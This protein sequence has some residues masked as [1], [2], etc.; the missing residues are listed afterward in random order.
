MAQPLTA[1]KMVSALRAEGVKI[2]E[3]SGWRTHN[4][5]HKGPWGGVNGIIIHHTA[6]HN[7]LHIVA[8]GRTGL[9][10][11]LA[12]AYL[13]KSGTVTLVGNGRANH[14]GRVAGNVHQAVIN[15]T[16]VPSASAAS[17]VDG[18]QH[19]YGIEIE[20]LG[21]GKDP[22][23]AAQYDAAVRWAAAICR[24]HGWSAKSVVG[25]KETSVEGKIDPSFSMT[26]FRADVAERLKHQPD[27]EG[28][29]MPNA[30]EIYKA[31]MSADKVPAPK[32]V[33]TS[34]AN[35]T[36]KAESYFPEIVD[37][38][39][40]NT[41][42]LRGIQDSLSELGK[43]VAALSRAVADPAQTGEPGA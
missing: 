41:E 10:G 17:T 26:K 2:A 30:E 15:E 12:H 21:T 16:A 36:W 11:P 24:A 35:P 28:D 32:S 18:N 8:D 14:A 37:R 4:R 5:N 34:D 23:P 33:S 29:D 40:K 39:N 31:V 22:Y 43:A 9:P 42:L 13:A 7:D 38:L 20:N 1:D 27:H 25:H 19:Y 6:G 3:R